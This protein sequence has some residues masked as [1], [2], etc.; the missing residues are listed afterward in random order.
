M[1]RTREAGVSI[2]PG[3]ESRFIGTKPQESFDEKWS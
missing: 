3:V 1:S 2:K